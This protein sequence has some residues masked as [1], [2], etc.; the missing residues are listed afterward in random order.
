MAS[1][2]PAP[3]TTTVGGEGVVVGEFVGDGGVGESVVI[4]CE[5]NRL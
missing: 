3:N 5:F 2:I 1:Q 4:V